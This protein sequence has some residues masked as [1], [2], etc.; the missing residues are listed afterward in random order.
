[1]CFSLS[2]SLL[3]CF[4]SLG[5]FFVLAPVFFSNPL[6]FFSFD[7]SF[8]N[9]A[10]RLGSV[11]EGMMSSVERIDEFSV[12]PSEAA[13]HLPDSDPPPSWPHGGAID[14]SDCVLRYRPELEVVLKGVSASIRAGEKVGVIGRTGSGKS[15]LMVALFRLVEL[16]AGRISVD[17]VDISKIGL[18][19]LRTRITLIPQDPVI[20]NGSVRYNLDPFSSVSDEALWRVLKLVNLETKIRG[21][22]GQLDFLLSEGESLSVGERQ[23]LC[24]ARALLRQTKILILDEVSGANKRRSGKR[25]TQCVGV[26]EKVSSIL[27]LSGLS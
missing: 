25:G 27:R 16:S 23:L 12:L 18:E 21:M 24:V 17:G 5:L 4:D 7:V 20:F 2:V 22:D 8:L 3:S 11:V 1:M 9:F 6:S 10:V 26:A 19:T 13:S 15:S 14:F